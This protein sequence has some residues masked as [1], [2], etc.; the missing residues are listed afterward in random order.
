MSINP[1]ESTAELTE[2]TSLFE[3][4]TEQ[5]ETSSHEQ[6][7]HRSYDS[8]QE[9]IF[10]VDVL[11]DGDFQ[12]VGL[13]PT[14]E[15]W[16]G[17]RSED[18]RGKRP[19]EVLPSDDAAKVRRHY[20]ECVHF[21]KRISYEECLQFNGM[22]TW[23]L[24]T[25]TPLR[26]ENSQIYRLIG[27]STNITECKQ[28]EERLQHQ[29]R[30]EQLLGATA[31]RIRQFLD[32]E[33]I[34]NETVTELR[35]FL[36]CDRVIIK[37]FEPDGSGV[38]VVE[39]TTVPGCPLLG[40]IIKDPCLTEKHMERYKQ[41]YIQAIEDILA[42]GL[43]PCYID[44]LASMQ[45]RAKLVV[46]ILLAQDLWGLLIAQQCHQPRQ[47]QQPEIDL[48]RQL[49][50]QLGT[51]VQQSQLYQQIEHF[52]AEQQLHK[53]KAE[54][55]YLVKFESIV[56]GM[57]EQICNSLDETQVLQRTLEELAHALNANCCQIELYSDAPQE[58]PQGGDE[59]YGAKPFLAEKTSPL[60]SNAATTVYT[61]GQ[62]DKAYR[63]SYHHIIATIAYE[64]TTTLPQCQGLTK[65]IAD[66]PEIYQPLL[67]KQPIQSM[68]IVPGWN[69]K[70]SVLAQIACP[71]FDAQGIL[72]NLWVKRPTQVAF[73]EFE[74]KLVQQVANGCAIAIRRTRLCEIIQTQAGELETLEHLKHEFLRTL[75]HELRTPV[76]SINLAAQTLESV[77]KQ[78]GLFEIELV[79]QLLNIL[80]KECQRESKLINDLLTLTYLEAQAEPLTLIVIDLQT[81]LPSI[82]EPFRELIQCQQ[83]QLH[84][85]INSDLPPLETDIT[86]LERIITELLN[87]AC[88][89]TSAGEAITVSV[90][91]TA[92][93]VVFSVSNSGVEI[94]TQELSQ[95]FDPFYRIPNNDPWKYGGTGLGLA[96]VR[97]LVKRIGASI[98][99]Q[100][101]AGK[102]TFTIKF[103]QFLRVAAA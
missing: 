53:Q 95:I 61:V 75:S 93:T 22:T 92:G 23:W 80:H 17:I 18:I 6:F 99:V 59:P 40:T 94:P 56:H 77:L 89:F 73:D 16:T 58:L 64:Y 100:S 74:Q 34:L 50:D 8:V 79:P 84:L 20:S 62:Q 103:P 101:A 91:Q 39:S 72:G 57:T 86:D 69:P 21:G 88:K 12:Y 76:T 36:A 54:L 15:R 87:N 13:N 85:M 7:L 47:W 43:A 66:F 9:S 70:L 19:E 3:Q 67:Q 37:R 90:S 65:Q 35:E 52:K 4:P 55:Q 10:V 1:S 68:E 102:T 63:S 81:W 30:R 45:V 28:P 71:I 97:K 48:L 27:T 14:H 25:L 49:A 32:L 44:S 60:Q 26:D 41:G 11:E 51:A 42:A 33:T 98:D 24:T 38:I 2:S 5:D 96:L 82:I 78:E 31:Q 83:Q 46:P 29:T